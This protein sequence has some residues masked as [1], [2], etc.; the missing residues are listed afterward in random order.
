[1]SATRPKARAPTAEAARVI[2]F[3]SETWLVLRFHWSVSR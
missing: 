3:S 1:M 2:E